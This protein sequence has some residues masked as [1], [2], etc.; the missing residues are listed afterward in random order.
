MILQNMVEKINQT[1]PDMTLI[2]AKLNLNNALRLYARKTKCRLAEVL[3]IES[4][5]SNGR[6]LLDTEIE[7]VKSAGFV[8]A[9]GVV[10]ESSGW[11][12]DIKDRYVYLSDD[13]GTLTDT[14]PSGASALRLRIVELPISLTNL[15]QSPAIPE[16]FH[17]ALVWKVLSDKAVV[18][19][20]KDLA[21]M[22]QAKWKEYIQE[23][24]R[25][26][27]KEANG[28]IQPWRSRWGAGVPAT[29][30]LDDDR[31]LV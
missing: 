12:F 9:N 22:A 7:S 11:K 26:A 20:A 30:S 27:N 10:I 1:F 4:D 2:E 6:A 19:G 24:I 3:V 14:F 8:D 5:F 21:V 17:E 23:G 29:L 18:K 31:D 16:E 25:Y 28:T 13:T 15:D